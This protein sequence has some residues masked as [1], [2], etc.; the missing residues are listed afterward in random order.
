MQSRIIVF[1]DNQF[2][3]SSWCFPVNLQ[4]YVVHSVAYGQKIYHFTNVTHSNPNWY[5]W[6]HGAM[7]HGLFVATST[8]DQ[9]G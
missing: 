9:R 7:I 1:M 6:L 3:G 5:T 8:S 4:C 2:V